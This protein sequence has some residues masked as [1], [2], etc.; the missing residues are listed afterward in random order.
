M[1]KKRKSKYRLTGEQKIECNKC[2]TSYAKLLMKKWFH[3]LNL[4]KG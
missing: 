2:A 3:E 4:K 1:S